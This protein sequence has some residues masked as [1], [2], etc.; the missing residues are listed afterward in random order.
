MYQ[1]ILTVDNRKILLWMQKAKNNGEYVCQVYSLPSAI[2]KPNEPNICTSMK[3]NRDAIKI[4]SASED[5]MKYV[6]L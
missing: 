2:E 6:K 1:K 3:V 4:I 5:K